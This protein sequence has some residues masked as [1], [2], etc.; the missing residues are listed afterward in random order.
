MPIG[1]WLANETNQQ[2]GETELQRFREWLDEKELLPFTLNGFPF[3]DFHQKIVKHEVYKPTWA[4]ESR[5]EYTLALARNLSVL[6]SGN[7]SLATISTLPLGWPPGDEDFIT[8]CGKNLTKCAAELRKLR[9]QTGVHIML[10]IEPEPGCILDTADDVVD[11]FDKHIDD[12]ARE[13]IGVCH[14]ICHSAVMFEPQKSAVEEYR[15][16]SI[17]IGKCQVSSAIEA[18]FLHSDNPDSLLAALS[19]FHEPRY[20]HQTCI[21]NEAN[22]IE[23]FEDLNQAIRSS[24][25]ENGTWRTHFHVPIYAKA[26]GQLATTQNE[27]IEF[28]NC[29][30]ASNMHFELE[31]YAWDVLPPDVSNLDLETNIERE[32]VWFKETIE[33]LS[34]N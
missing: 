3:G 1:L 17:R 11:F 12:S 7:L 33:K 6:V 4:S 31:T 26:I 19:K 8:A 15:R 13:Y 5:L 24:E 29:I 20:L 34:A 32:I 16:N 10:C 14:D 27:I 30:D 22:Q 21:R 2:L 25:S 28:L 23:F 18:N 9:D